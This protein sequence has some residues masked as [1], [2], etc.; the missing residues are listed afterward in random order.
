MLL[1]NKL[2]LF[3]IAIETILKG[4]GIANRNEITMQTNTA[5][6]RYSM[7]TNFSAASCDFARYALDKMLKFIVFWGIRIYNQGRLTF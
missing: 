3:I 7:T 1:P 6:A 5:N 2:P 4:I